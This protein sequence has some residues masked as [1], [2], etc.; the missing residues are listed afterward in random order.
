MAQAN[1]Y[2]DDTGAE[3]YDIAFDWRRDREANFAEACLRAFGERTEGA[4]LDLACGGG[5]FLAEMRSRGWRAAG[6]DLSPLMVERARARVGGDCTLE[7]ANMSRFTVTGAFDIATCWLDSLT[8]LLTNDDIIRHLQSVARVVKDAGLYLLDIGF[9][10]WADPMWHQPQAEWQ[11]DF[12]NGWSASRGSLEVYHDGCDGPPCDGMSHTCTEYMYFRATDKTCGTV[13]E[14]FYKAP[15]RAL[16]PQEFAA[17]VSASGVF[18]VAAW[19]AGNFDLSQ[20]L[21]S[22]HGRG[23]GLV[24]LRKPAR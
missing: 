12:S 2:L 23:R 15:K 5:H 3:L 20:R 13:A 21:E 1:L 19:F 17:L 7:V 11:P 18:E 24:L 4:V 10:R 16:H 22:T 6:V 8:Y 14:H 9:G